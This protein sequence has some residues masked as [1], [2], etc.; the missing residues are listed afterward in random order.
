[1][2]HLKT[3]EDIPIEDVYK[4]NLSSII[5]IAKIRPKIDAIYPRP[6]YLVERKTLRISWDCFDMKV[7]IFS[8]EPYVNFVN[9]ENLRLTAYEGDVLATVDRCLDETDT[10]GKYSQ[11]FDGYVCEFCA[12][13]GSF[14]DYPR[15]LDM[16]SGIARSMDAKSK[17]FLQVIGNYD[18]EFD[19][20]AIISELATRELGSKTDSST[21]RI[22]HANVNR[23]IEFINESVL[24][25][26]YDRIELEEFFPYVMDGNLERFIKDYPTYEIRFL[27]ILKLYQELFAPVFME[28]L[29]YVIHCY[30]SEQ[31]S[32]ILREKRDE[33][34]VDPYQYFYN[35]LK[36]NENQI[37][38]GPGIRFDDP[39]DIDKFVTRVENSLKSKNP[40][41]IG[42]H[43][44]FGR[45]F[46][47]L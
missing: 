11:K 5:K 38:I 17:R 44:H 45:Y 8:H 24:E 34:H 3:L 26:F 10:E 31:I 30:N 12:R 2:N 25:R 9:M 1:M 6:E 20:M 27:P 13:T 41:T 42:F 35:D 19:I 4:R 18:E 16:F 47:I 39:K 40:N 46:V 29:E 23:Y 37:S 14:H 43:K 28:L 22:S 36:Y 7:F 32:K 33:D 15:N 21:F